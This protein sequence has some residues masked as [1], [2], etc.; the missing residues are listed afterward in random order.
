MKR[1]LA[2]PSRSPLASAAVP[3]TLI[4]SLAVVPSAP[5]A[6]ADDTPAT[7]TETTT[8]T[9]AATPTETA[10]E[11][12]TETA[13]A[14]ATETPAATTTPAATETKNASTETPKNT[15]KNEPKNE[16][17][18]KDNGA[19]VPDGYQVPPRAPLGSAYTGS[20]PLSVGLFFG[21]IGLILGGIASLPPVQ[22]ELAKRG[23]VIPASSQLI[24]A[25]RR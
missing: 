16:P 8:E 22:A 23:I 20:A 5:T 11:T 14:T 12:P 1:F 21:A 9:T 3:A 7:T 13:T 4:A 15:P 24:P 10:T 25:L 6:L 18:K 19:K 17:K 2:G